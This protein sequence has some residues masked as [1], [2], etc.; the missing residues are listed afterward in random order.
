MRSGCCGGRFGSGVTILGGGTPEETMGIFDVGDGRQFFESIERC[1]AFYQSQEVKSTEALLYIIMGLNHL[2]EWIAPGYKAKD[3]PKTPEERFSRMIYDHPDHAAIR[4][5]CNAT[6]HS[7]KRVN[8]STDHEAN[9][10]A[11]PDFLG[12][13][14]IFKGPPVAHFLDGRSIEVRIGPVLTLYRSW[15]T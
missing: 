12:V 15:Y 13:A 5:L 10:L 11:W 3:E 14:D 8:T 2:R 6:K 9:V 7:T 1:Y 4:M